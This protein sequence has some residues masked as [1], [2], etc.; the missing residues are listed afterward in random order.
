MR[1]AA[2]ADYSGGTALS[3]KSQDCHTDTC[4]GENKMSNTVST[5][6]LA[7]G[8]HHTWTVEHNLDRDTWKR[9][10]PF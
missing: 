3:G 5:G 2:A 8:S 9:S 4:C 6:G 1:A 7:T 10:I